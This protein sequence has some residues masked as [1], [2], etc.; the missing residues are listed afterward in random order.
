M[1][2]RCQFEKLQMS[3]CIS[4]KQ[5]SHI[6][7]VAFKHPYVVVGDGRDAGSAQPS[8]LVDTFVSVAKVKKNRLLCEKL[9][10]LQVDI[11]LLFKNVY[12]QLVLGMF[13]FFK[14]IGCVKAL[15]GQKLRCVFFKWPFSV[16]A[17][18]I[19]LFIRLLNQIMVCCW[20]FFYCA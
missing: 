17:H 7:V 6:I 2:F 1:Y 16:K 12:A 4:F 18:C 20:F 9:L 10:F 11:S 5:R 3:I 19:S 14:H 15:I 8:G 13:V